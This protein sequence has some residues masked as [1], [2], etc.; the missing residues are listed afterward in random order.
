MS[1]DDEEDPRRAYQELRKRFAS[2][3]GDELKS[4]QWLVKTI[5]WVLEAHAKHVDAE[6]LRKKY[7]GAGPTIHPTRPS[8]SRLGTPAS[9]EERARPR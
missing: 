5:Q 7:P 9:W 1:V 4:G 2:T 3:A 6:Y 8:S